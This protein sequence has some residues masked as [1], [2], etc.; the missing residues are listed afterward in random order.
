MNKISAYYFYFKNSVKIQMRPSCQ[1]NDFTDIM[2]IKIAVRFP[3]LF[4]V[5]PM[6]TGTGE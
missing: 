1:E 6:A 3:V 5:E 2:G 4:P